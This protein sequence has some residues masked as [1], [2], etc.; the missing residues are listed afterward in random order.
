[1]NAADCL[2]REHRDETPEVKWF[3]RTLRWWRQEVLVCFATGGVSNGGTEAI[4]G[5]V[6]KT[7]RLAH[8]FRHFTNYRSRIL[9]AVDGSRCSDGHGAQC[10]RW[11]RFRI[12]A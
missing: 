1:V 3:G 11:R 7:R 10:C 12:P 4:N 6:E 9:L 5:V 8:G 2:A